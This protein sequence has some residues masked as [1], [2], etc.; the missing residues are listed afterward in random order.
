MQAGTVTGCG[1][2]LLPSHE[3]DLAPLGQ[4]T[5]PLTVPSTSVFAHWVFS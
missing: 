5:P 2:D 4:T 1:A 3:P